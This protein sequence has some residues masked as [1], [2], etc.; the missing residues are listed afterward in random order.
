MMK[1]VTLTEIISL[2]TNYKV[3][4]KFFYPVLILFIIT[5]IVSIHSRKFKNKNNENIIKMANFEI[6]ENEF[7]GG[8]N[9]LKNGK[10]D[11]YL[12]TIEEDINNVKF[13]SKQFKKIIKNYRKYDIKSRT[14]I[15][16]FRK[17]YLELRNQYLKN[18]IE[19]YEELKNIKMDIIN[20]EVYK[21]WKQK[22]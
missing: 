7:T 8:Y 19:N 4:I 6:P 10:Y 20:N 1:M 11:E 21:E 18:L 15:K 9:M 17:H 14:G 2:F 5:L 16:Y 22:Q 3:S 12:K 13:I